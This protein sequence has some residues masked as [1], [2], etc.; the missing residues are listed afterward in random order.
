MMCHIR[1]GMPDVAYADK[2]RQRRIR[3]PAR[4]LDVGC[5]VTALSDLAVA[6]LHSGV[7]LIRRAS[8]ASGNRLGR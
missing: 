2:T 5:G 4:T 7:G 6:A 3:Q 8:V 1:Q